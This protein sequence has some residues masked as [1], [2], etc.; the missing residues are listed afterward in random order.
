MTDKC[1]DCGVPLDETSFKSC[2]YHLANEAD[3]EEAER[4]ML[5]ARSWSQKIEESADFDEM[6]DH[7][8]D[9]FRSIDR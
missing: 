9:Y 3:E 6:K 2:V 8:V 4:R 7:L 1:P 5:S